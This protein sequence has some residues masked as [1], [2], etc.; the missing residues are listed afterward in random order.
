MLKKPY[1]TPLTTCYVIV[2]FPKPEYGFRSKSMPRPTSPSANNN[3]NNN[4]SLSVLKM[5]DKASL[6][7]ARKANQTTSLSLFSTRRICS[8][9]QRKKQL[10][11]LATN[12]DDNI[13]QSHSLFACWREK[14]RQVENGL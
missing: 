2:L 6:Y 3:N 5:A 1:F 11:W 9:K 10:D 7:S 13:I 4:N 14:N 12:T 8:R